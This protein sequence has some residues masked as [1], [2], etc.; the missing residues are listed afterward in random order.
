M[1]KLQIRSQT[2]RVIVPSP[3]KLMSVYSALAAFRKGL[4]DRLSDNHAR[5]FV[6]HGSPLECRVFVVGLNAATRLD[7]PF[8]AFWSDETGFDRD[9]F[10]RS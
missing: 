3:L 7:Q 1:A 5:P 10:S 8:T 4:L 6:C 9:A 2:D